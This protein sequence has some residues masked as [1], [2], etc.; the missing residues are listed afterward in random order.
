MNKSELIELLKLLS[1][2]E[3]WSFA[4]KHHLPDHILENLNNQVSLVAERILN[5]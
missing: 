1:Q 3:A 2:L 4:E 5:D